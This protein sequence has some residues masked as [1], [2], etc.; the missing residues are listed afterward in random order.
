MTGQMELSAQMA[1]PLEV[2]YRRAVAREPVD[3]HM[4]TP[5]MDG[6]MGLTQIP[7]LQVGTST[8]SSM[9]PA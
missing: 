1:W 2:P 7:S 4:L 8:H 3:S 9:I 6:V 5:P